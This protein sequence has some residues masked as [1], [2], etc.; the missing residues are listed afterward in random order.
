[1]NQ[2]KGHPSFT[3]AFG[4]YLVLLAV[5]GTLKKLAA[6]R[7]FLTTSPANICDAQRE[8]MGFL[9]NEGIRLLG[10]QCGRAALFGFVFW[11]SKK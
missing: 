9:K 11:A 7:Q 8:R 3:S 2:K 5:V 10:G 4:G 6:L 1:M